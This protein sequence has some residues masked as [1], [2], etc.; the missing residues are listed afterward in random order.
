MQQTTC[1]NFGL[2]QRNQTSFSLIINWWNH[3]KRFLIGIENLFG[4]FDNQKK[5]GNHSFS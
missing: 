3:V 4:G 5:T 1:C 2:F